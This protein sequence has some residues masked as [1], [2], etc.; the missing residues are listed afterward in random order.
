MNKLY[1]LSAENY[2]S[3]MFVGGEVLAENGGLIRFNSAT[4]IQSNSA[5]YCYKNI[6]D[7]GSELDSYASGN[8]GID[9]CFPFNYLHVYSL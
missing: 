9:L 7:V 6:S 5:K 1:F 3:V 2:P 8:A 4:M